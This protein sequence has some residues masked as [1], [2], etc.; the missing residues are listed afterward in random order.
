MKICISNRCNLF[1][2]SADY[3]RI[4]FDILKEKW[5]IAP[6]LITARIPCLV[7]RESLLSQKPEGLEC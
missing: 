4:D 7:L 3:E 5:N 2:L 1:L 6:Q